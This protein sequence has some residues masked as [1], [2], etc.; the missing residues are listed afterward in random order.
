M[1][2]ETGSIVVAGE[3]L[4]DLVLMPDGQVT[5]HP[6]GGPYNAA[7]TAA[8]L[9]P[10]T[11]FLGALSRDAFGRHLRDSLEADG[12]SFAEDLT[13]DSPT[14][15]AVAEIGHDGAAGYQ[16]YFERT[17]APALGAEQAAL[18]M[19]ATVHSL[20]VGTLGL[21]LEPMADTLE[22]LLADP[23]DGALRSVDPNCRPSAI[24][25]LDS[26]LERLSRAMRCADLVKLS[27]DDA[28]VIAPGRDPRE[29][30][31][32]LL[33]EGPRLVLLTL[34]ARGALAMTG[35]WTKE[36]PAPRVE[37]I[38]T[39]GAG[40]AFAGAF[41][42]RWAS[43]GLGVSELDDREA[44]GDAASF[45]ARVAAIVCSRAGADPPTLADLG[46]GAMAG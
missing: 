16:F 24:D 21:V 37:V 18:A 14:T 13:V 6:G 4:V 35:A 41:L 27:D 5:A 34:G 28:A 44:V 20:H 39:V 9:G 12:V 42:A 15:L 38:D 7:R 30:A 1:A 29:T 33:G 31:E 17:S 32:R 40:D 19:P 2:G 45:A 23:P 8:R 11:A 10:P 43:A 26:Y 3:A 36:I 22:A 25:D 46:E